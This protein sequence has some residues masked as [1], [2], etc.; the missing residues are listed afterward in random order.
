MNMF[1]RIREECQLEY[2]ERLDE[3]KQIAGGG[4]KEKEIREM[5]RLCSKLFIFTQKWESCR[6]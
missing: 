1:N 5:F 4:R 3:D 2:L 6:R